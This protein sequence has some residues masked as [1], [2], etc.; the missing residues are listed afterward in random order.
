V[1]NRKQKQQRRLVMSNQ[2]EN[3]QMASMKH[4]DTGIFGRVLEAIATPATFVNDTQKPR[5][6]WMAD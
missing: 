3:S 2:R 5:V 6:R 1:K 4:N